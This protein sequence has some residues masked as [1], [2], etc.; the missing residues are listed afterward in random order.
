MQHLDAQLVTLLT[1]LKRH[2]CSKI[3]DI[4]YLC[5]FTLFVQREKLGHDKGAQ[6]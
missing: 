6:S 3:E 2:G 1:F 4:G 5:I